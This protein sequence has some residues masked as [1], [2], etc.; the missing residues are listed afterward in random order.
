M[1]SPFLVKPSI[2]Y[3]TSFLTAVAEVQNERGINPFSAFVFE[4]KLNLRDLA[5]DS[6]F[7]LLLREFDLNSKR[8]MIDV[9]GRVP[10]TTL[11][12]IDRND[13]GEEFFVGRINIRHYLNEA[14]RN[15]FGHLSYLIRPT[16]RGLGYG[17]TILDLALKESHKFITDLAKNRMRV[18]VTC[19]IDNL[20]SRKVIEKNGGVFEKIVSVNNGLHKEMLFWIKL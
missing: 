19:K 18:M 3:K 7:E 5:D 11:W 12:L 2:K 20:F 10:S 1:D 8:K 14:L 16:A 13:F 15:S 9:S 17:S 6:N 4:N